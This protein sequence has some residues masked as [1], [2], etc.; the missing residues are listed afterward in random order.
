MA[1]GCSI[2]AERMVVRAFMDSFF[3]PV[4]LAACCASGDGS[5]SLNCAARSRRSFSARAFEAASSSAAVVSAVLRCTSPSLKREF[6]GDDG[7]INQ[8]T[9]LSEL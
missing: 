2:A 8:V 1:I 3:L 5:T 4:A 7:G 9:C 6:F